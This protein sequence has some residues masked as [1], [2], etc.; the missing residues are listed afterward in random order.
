MKPPSKSKGIAPLKPKLDGIAAIKDRQDLARVLGG[1]TPR[2]CRCF[3]QHEF[4]NRATC[5]ASGSPRA[6]RI[7]RT[8]IPI[9]CRAVSECPIATIIFPR[10]HIW[11]S[12]ASNT[13]RTSRPCSSWPA[14]TNPPSARPASSRSKRRW[15]GACH[16][17]RIGGRAYGRLLET[18]RT[19]RQSARA[20]LAR[21][22]RRGRPE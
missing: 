4:R 21:A 8:A 19:G 1:A 11:L 22:A 20:R 16:A 2:R 18:R 15:P 5:S 17:R 3:E 12:C 10:V 14:S 13:R 7:H 6:S 9:C